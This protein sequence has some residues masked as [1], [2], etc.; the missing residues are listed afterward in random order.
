MSD[1]SRKQPL[2]YQSTLATA[3]PGEWTGPR[4]IST[5]PP[6]HGISVLSQPLTG[7][8]PHPDCETTGYPGQSTSL[9]VSQ[10]NVPRSSFPGVKRQ[11]KVTERDHPYGISFRFKSKA[12]AARVRGAADEKP[13]AASFAWPGGDSLEYAQGLTLPLSLWGSRSEGEF[14]CVS[15]IYQC[16]TL[17]AVRSPFEMP[18]ADSLQI[19]DGHLTSVTLHPSS[20][21]GSTTTPT[22]SLELSLPPSISIAAKLADNQ[23]SS[24][25]AA[26]ASVIPL[27]VPGWSVVYNPQQDE[28][29]KLAELLYDYLQTNPEPTIGSPDNPFPSADDLGIR[30]ISILSA[31]IEHEDMETF[32]CTF[33]GDIQT[34]IEVSL[35]HQRTFLRYC[36]K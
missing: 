12:F 3:L 15:V 34:D 6:R 8:L 24:T 27:P 17:Y 30:G 21:I 19:G 1:S 5:P 7:F 35:A 32:T 26:P 29:N 11:M 20:P 13:S 23:L 31:F 25:P 16:M 22:A 33:C 2:P 18:L 4:K 10:C 9:A 28:R 14:C 36:M